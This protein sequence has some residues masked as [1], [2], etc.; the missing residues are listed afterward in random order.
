MEKFVYLTDAQRTDQWFKNRLGCITGSRFKDV[1]AIGAKGQYLKARDDYK[2]ELV[3]ERIIGILGRKDVYVTDAMRWGQLNEE[4]ARTT[5]QLRTGNKVTEAG[6]AVM[7]D[8]DGKKLP[9]GV[10]TDGL[11]GEYGNLEIKSLEPYNHLYNVIK[12]YQITQEM[13]DDYKAQ[14]QGQM[15]V[16]DRL[17]TDFVGSD[18]RMP[19]GLDLLAVR[20]ER[21]DDYCEWL[22]I[23]LLKFA[24]EVDREVRYFLQFLPVCERTCRVCGEIFIDQ[25]AICPSCKMASTM[26]NKILKP[27]ELQLSSMDDLKQIN[28][29]NN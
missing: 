22:L 16:L 8:E 29:A 17:W 15:L 24:A 13:P 23:E 10:S 6:F 28:I 9:I 14:V 27:A 5:Y 21:D 1:V 4:I 11:V 26:V 2:K 3:S 25:L 12:A 7:L 19:A 18:S 20:V